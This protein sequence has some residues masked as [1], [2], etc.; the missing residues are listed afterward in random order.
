MRFRLAHLFLEV[1]LISVCLAAVRLYPSFPPEQALAHLGIFT[2]AV[3][4]GCAALGGVVL[5]PVAGLLAGAT[6][7]VAIGPWWFLIH[8]SAAC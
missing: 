1:F 2:V 8:A 6:I 7:C 5:R 4:S 3:L